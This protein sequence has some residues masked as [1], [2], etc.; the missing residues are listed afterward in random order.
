ML[1][2]KTNAKSNTAEEFVQIYSKYK[3]INECMSLVFPI[4]YKA[5]SAETDL[6]TASYLGIFPFYSCVCVCKYYL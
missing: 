5:A 2:K 1:E 6:K 3:W 4:L